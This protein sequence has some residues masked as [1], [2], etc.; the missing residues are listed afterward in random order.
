[1]PMRA[2]RPARATS[3]RQAPRAEEHRPGGPT[4]GL[5]P[6]A[7]RTTL[8][9]A[10]ALSTGLVQ[11]VTETVVT[12]VRAAQ[13]VGAEIGSTAVSA[14]RGSIRA[15]EE[16]GGDLGRLA[17]SAT[18]GAVGAGREVGSEVGR[19]AAEAAQG[20]AR[21]L[22]FGGAAATRRPLRKMS[23]SGS[24]QRRPRRQSAA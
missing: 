2:R 10:E 22:R 1:M 19:L 20:A 12:A 24:R 16:I 4:D 6:S 17:K 13:E 3:R 14:V 8:Q 15:A 5:V 21:L 11:A 23:R 18:G 9:G 7:I